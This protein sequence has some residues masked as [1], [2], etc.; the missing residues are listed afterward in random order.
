MCHWVEIRIG[1]LLGHCKV[2]SVLSLWQVILNVF[3]SA[4]AF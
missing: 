3:S 1:T 2:V 4:G